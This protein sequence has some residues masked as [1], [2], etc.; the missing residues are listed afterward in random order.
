[1][2]YTIK[3]IPT[4]ERPRERLKK[5]GRG[6]LS[7]QELLA[8]ILKT[9][10]KNKNVTELALDILKEYPIE[11]L[12]DIS[13]NKLTQIKGVGEVKA[14]ELLAVIELGRR[15]YIKTTKE[16]KKLSSAKEI[17]LAT[18][19]LFIN[20]HQENLYALY[21]NTK[22]ELIET[23]LL[24]IGTVNESIVHPREL[25]KEA[26]RLSATY[27]VCLHNH[28]SNDT[29]PSQ[30]DIFFTEQIRNTG[31]MHGI[32]VVDH[33]IV[34]QDNFYSFY[35]NKKISIQE[36]LWKRIKNIKKY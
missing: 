4:S 29:T 11:N 24:F 17:F 26:Y 2:S 25:F 12:Q 20:Q 28:P 15:I 34:G 36:E 32:K 23:K 27:I 8:I 16:L 5:Y 21:F 9:G 35:E 1:M 19:H 7:N 31:I 13:I 10:T 3:E 14:L 22:Q 33:I 30:A 6:S 18:R